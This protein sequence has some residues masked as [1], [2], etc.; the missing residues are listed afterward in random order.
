MKSRILSAVCA[1]LLFA[2]L[3]APVRG[4]ALTTSVLGMFPKDVGEFAYAD[5]KTARRFPWFAQF[6]DQVVPGRFR[7]FE[8]FLAAAGIDPDTQVDEL[9]WAAVMSGARV[10]PAPAP[11]DIE[12]P[13]KNASGEDQKP[14]APPAPQ[15]GEQIVG[16]ALG[17]FSPSSAE[18]YFE[19]Q[20][21]PV[22]KVR[23]FS[24]F[25][26]GTGS[27]PG[28]I[29]F[30]F[31]DS[32]TAAFG[33]RQLLEKLIE[34]RY[35]AEESFLRNDRLFPLVDEVNGRGIIWAATDQDYTRIGMSQLLPEAGQFPEAG[36][37][38]A[39]VK[40]MT[41]EVLADHGIET[42]MSGVCGSPED[43]NTLA[44][45]LQAGMLL[46][47]YQEA[48][49]NP[50]LAKA[51]DNSTVSARGDRLQVNFVLTEDLLIALL[52]RNTFA[53]KF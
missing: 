13:G 17:N 44:Q 25:G 15:T 48:A 52:R 51:I 32:N 45:L 26:F 22:V 47:R 50:D 7:Q 16:I 28:D 6:K 46:R 9:A 29:F 11:P 43:A 34:V 21:L 40:A 37:L 20:K 38:F 5:L 35:G 12:T 49:T 53:V 23:G 24:L 2:A 27:G 14:P 19:Q 18:K 41:V 8:K 42:H 30:F 3:A 4:G 39:R 36:K 31:I 1:A 33:H 10:V